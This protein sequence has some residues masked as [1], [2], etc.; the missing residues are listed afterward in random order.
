MI[1]LVRLT[2]HGV[3]HPKGFEEAGIA[4]ENISQLFT[5]LDW[6]LQKLREGSE[7][8]TKNIFYCAAHHVG[9]SAKYPPRHGST[10]QSQEIVFFDIDESDVQR[11]GE[12]PAVVARI[13]GV[14]KDTVTYYTTGNGVQ[15]FV[16]LKVPIRS[17]K[18]L[19]ELKPA[20]NEIADKITLALKEVGLPG[21]ADK[22][23][24][25]ARILRLPGTINEKPEKGCKEAIFHYT[26]NVPVDIDLMAVSGLSKLRQENISPE[27]VRRNY[28]K[29]DFSEIVKE[30]RFFQKILHDPTIIHEPDAFDA[31]SLLSCMDPGDKAV[32]NEKEYTPKEL[33][34]HLVDGAVNSKSLARQDFDNKWEGASKYGCRKCSTVNSRMPDACGHCPHFGKVPTPLALKSEEHVGSEAMGYWTLTKDGVYREPNYEDLVKIYTRKNSYI[35]QGR[36]AMFDFDG[37]KYI[38]ATDLHVESWVER[39]VNPS[40]PLRNKHCL[41]F[42]KKMKR[43]GSVSEKEALYLFG[44]AMKGKINCANGVLDVVRG[45]LLPHSPQY[46]FRYVLPYDYIPDDSSEFFFEWLETITQGREDLIKSIMDLMGYI[47]WPGY[48]DHVFAYLVGEGANGKSTLIHII[49]AMVGRENHAAVGIQQLGS[50]RFAPAQLEGKLANLSEESSGYMMSY[51]EMNVIKN[52][53]SGGLIEAERKNQDGFRFVNKAKLIFSA[54]KTPIIKEKGLAITRRMLVIP[55]DHTITNPDSRIEEQLIEEVPKITSMIVRHIQ[56]NLKEH[57]GRYKVFRGGQ[58][59]AE[60]QRLMLLKGDSAFEWGKEHLDSNKD[61]PL[62]DCVL[63]SEAY[64]NYTEWCRINGYKSMNVMQF[65]STIKKFIVSSSVAE[66][67]TKQWNGQKQVRVFKKTKWKEQEL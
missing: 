8:N 64:G 54:N 40:Y 33:A 41:E 32:F 36:D 49:Q 6:F 65:S 9:D 26:K 48:D 19:D 17:R 62:E 53:S 58:A 4:A 5:N 50:N 25:A 52:L 60:A 23:W 1:Y 57:G 51:E 56:A 20:Y 55:F 59:A 66:G 45:E 2:E 61:Y 39:T 14:D 38:P 67:D 11:A 21:Y 28:P 3:V 7:E 24:D 47:L 63:I 44:E 42:V 27:E 46:G 31:L 37:Q 16:Y 34:K 18:Y 13:L 35:V 43:R 12:Y 10:F 30:C 29:P 15:C 22:I